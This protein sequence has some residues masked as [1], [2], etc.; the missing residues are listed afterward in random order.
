MGTD[1]QFL[2]SVFE[3]AM[4]AARMTFEGVGRVGAMAAGHTEDKMVII[5]MPFRTPQEKELMCAAVRLIFAKFKIEL[6]SFMCEAYVATVRCAQG[7]SREDVRREARNYVGKAKEQPGSEEAI[8]VF[9]ISREK[10]RQGGYTIIRTPGM[11][12][13]LQRREETN[14]TEGLFSELLPMENLS[15]TPEERSM[16]EMLMRSIRTQKGVHN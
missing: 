7:T 11:R 16:A 1:N 13:R 9:A 5:P 15:A 3:H 14:D 6:Y 4:N 2:N 10:R 12:A 8:L